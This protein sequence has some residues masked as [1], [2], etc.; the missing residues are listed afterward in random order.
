M[1]WF[2]LDENF[3]DHPKVA[4]LSDFAFRLHVTALCYCSRMSTDGV[5]D[6]RSALLSRASK[7]EQRH[8]VEA[9]NELIVA[10]LWEIGQTIGTYEIHD[11]LHYNTSRAD[12]QE[13]SLKRAEAGQKGGL[14]AGR[15]GGKHRNDR[16]S[17]QKGFG[18]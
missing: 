4:P 11:F 5:I 13:L 16:D 15:W 9:V 17:D 6:Y 7:V 8:T 2:R 18:I 10:G 14:K 1:S 3:A 12:R